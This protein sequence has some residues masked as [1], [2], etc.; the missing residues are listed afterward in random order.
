[1]EGWLKRKKEKGSANRATHVTKKY[2]AAPWFLAAAALPQVGT[3]H[4][5]PTAASKV[6]AVGLFILSVAQ[7]LSSSL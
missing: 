2:S 1:M 7:T 3:A 5:H 6:R 4:S